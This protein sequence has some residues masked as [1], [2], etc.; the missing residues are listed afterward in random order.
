MF[1]FVT[2]SLAINNDARKLLKLHGMKTPA[3][4][5]RITRNSGFWQQMTILGTSHQN[6]LYFFSVASIFTKY[7]VNSQLKK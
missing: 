4:K 5:G 2:K 7:W 6:T 3:V 1:L